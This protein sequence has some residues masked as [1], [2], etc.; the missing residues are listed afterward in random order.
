MDILLEIDGID[1]PN[2]VCVQV[3]MSKGQARN[4]GKIPE[5]DIMVVS[6]QPIVAYLP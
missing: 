6:M 3:R 4:L 2:N 5:R 1:G